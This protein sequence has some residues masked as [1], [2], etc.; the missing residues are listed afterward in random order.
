MVS[1]R[2]EAS[3][4]YSAYSKEMEAED[5]RHAQAMHDIQRRY[6]AEAQKIYDKCV[7]VNGRH[8]DDGG[9]FYASCANCG[10]TDGY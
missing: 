3:A 7:A 10:Y 4:V 9:M 1:F 8:I 5:L 2:D 6:E